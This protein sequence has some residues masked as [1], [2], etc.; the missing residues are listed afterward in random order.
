MKKYFFLAAAALVAMCACTKTVV[1]EAPDQ[2]IGF[3]VASY[4]PQTKANEVSAKDI[5]TKQMA[6]TSLSDSHLKTVFTDLVTG[7]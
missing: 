2:A 3:N 7:T 4:V 6:L 5:C 1:N